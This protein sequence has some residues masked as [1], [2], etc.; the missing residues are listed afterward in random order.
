[1][2]HLKEGEMVY[3]NIEYLSEGGEWRALGSYAAASGELLVLAIAGMVNSF[4]G[5]RTQWR[6]RIRY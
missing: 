4:Y 5:A 1:L 3:A 6:V 2:G